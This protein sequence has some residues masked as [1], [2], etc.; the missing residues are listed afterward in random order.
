MPIARILSGTEENT[1]LYLIDCPSSLYGL[2]HCVEDGARVEPQQEIESD[3]T[4]DGVEV[5]V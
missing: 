3:R 1:I 2:K 5:H 4:D